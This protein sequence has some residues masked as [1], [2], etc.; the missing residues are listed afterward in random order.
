MPSIKDERR[1]KIVNKSPCGIPYTVA[2][3]E[4]FVKARRVLR[5]L[6]RDTARTCLVMEGERIASR[7][8]MLIL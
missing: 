6:P 4:G 1:F 8:S 2:R 5:N 3:V 7:G